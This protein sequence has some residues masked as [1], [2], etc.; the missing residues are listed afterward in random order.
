[1][2]CK[3]VNSVFL[4]VSDC[5]KLKGSRIPQRQPYDQVQEESLKLKA[6]KKKENNHLFKVG[7]RHMYCLKCS[8]LWTAQVISSSISDNYFSPPR[9]E[10]AVWC[11][12]TNAYLSCDYQLV[13]SQ[14]NFNCVVLFIRVSLNT[15]E[16]NPKT[17]SSIY[18]VKVQRAKQICLGDSWRPTSSH[19]TNSFSTKPKENAN[20]QKIISCSMF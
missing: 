17:G 13:I 18:H 5:V 6:K 9:P 15:I 19:C 11:F 12:K 3:C 7:F 1:M 8:E 14:R 2:K 10:S 4:I 16:G 20:Q